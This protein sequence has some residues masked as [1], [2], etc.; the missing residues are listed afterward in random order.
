MST[1]E[2]GPQSGPND[3]P[4]GTLLRFRAR[5]ANLEED[6]FKLV[7]GEHY[8][9]LPH[10]ADLGPA[11]EALL[12]EQH[13]NRVTDTCIPEEEAIRHIED[14]LMALWTTASRELTTI[15]PPSIPL[16][17]AALG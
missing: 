6:L 15:L 17:L 10:Y 5:S 8:V 13:L 4:K 3:S 2:I 9:D 16:R 7:A 12:L 14:H 1:A 11:D